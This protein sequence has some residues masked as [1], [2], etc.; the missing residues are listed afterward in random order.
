ML[1]MAGNYEYKMANR[2]TTYLRYR[3]SEFSCLQLM[4]AESSPMQLVPLTSV[5]QAPKVVWLIHGID[6]IKLLEKLI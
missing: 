6:Q 3:V 2:Y 5:A 1:S 4:D